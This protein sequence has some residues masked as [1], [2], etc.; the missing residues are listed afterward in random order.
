MSITNSKFFL[1]SESNYEKIADETYIQMSDDSQCRILRSQA[2]KKQKNGYTLLMVPGWGSVVLGWDEVLIEAMND[3]DIVYFETRE[4]GSSKLT[5]KSKTD[6]HRLSED[7]LEVIQKLQLNTEKLIIVSSSFGTSIVAQGIALKKFS[8]KLIVFVG[9]HLR[10]PIPPGLRYILPILPIFLIMLY[11]PIGLYW[12][13]KKM[14]ESPE[15]AA[16]YYRVTQE[17]DPRKW[18]SFG[19]K[20][21]RLRITDI[22]PKIEC[23]VLVIGA[24]KDK[25]H[26]IKDSIRIKSLIK[27]SA[28]LD[29]QTNKNTHDR[30]LVDAIREHI[31]M[32]ENNIFNKK[33]GM[34]AKENIKNKL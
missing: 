14:T 23:N 20:A 30:P 9:A 19:K 22:Y 6:I 28:Y 25:M 17:A 27:N 26:K 13:K 10:L 16:K 3:F 12:M 15:H 33:K 29:L 18:K 21:A 7:L 1:K 24:E 31:L 8:A 4:K 5:K 34:K 32:L 11:K 2:P